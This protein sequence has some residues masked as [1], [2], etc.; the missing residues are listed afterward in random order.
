[1]AVASSQSKRRI[2]CE[3]NRRLSLAL[4]T[5]EIAEND[6]VVR[7]QGLDELASASARLADGPHAARA[8]SGAR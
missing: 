5:V 8:M 4:V 7:F 6:D 2:G 3:V 1:M